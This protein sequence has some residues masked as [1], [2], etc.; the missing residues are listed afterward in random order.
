MGVWLVGCVRTAGGG[1]G[2][3]AA[4]AADPGALEARDAEGVV[5]VVAAA[6][7]SARGGLVVVAVLL[8]LGTCDQRRQAGTFV[9]SEARRSKGERSVR[10]IPHPGCMF[11]RCGVRRLALAPSPASASSL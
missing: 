10:R 5:V 11:S 2:D 7:V 4:D 6:G 8:C 1:G 3:A 9:G